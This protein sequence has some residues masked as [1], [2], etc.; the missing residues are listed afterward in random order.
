MAENTSIGGEGGVQVKAC[1]HV[2]CGQ[3]PF[4]NL[5]FTQNIEYILYKKKT[6][7]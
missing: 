4:L 2:I 6:A 1:G 7:Y 3:I 5:I